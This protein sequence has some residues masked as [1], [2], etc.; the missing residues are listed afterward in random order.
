MA[1]AATVALVMEATEE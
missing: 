1:L